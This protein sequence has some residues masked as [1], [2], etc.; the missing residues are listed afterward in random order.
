[1]TQSVTLM[2]PRIINGCSGNDIIIAFGHLSKL[3]TMCITRNR[4]ISCNTG[5]EQIKS[6]YKQTLSVPNEN[7]CYI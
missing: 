2:T 7:Y 4:T 3:M 1:M 5:R 6:I